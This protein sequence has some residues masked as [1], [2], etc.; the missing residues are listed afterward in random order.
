M[1]RRNFINT[2][3]SAAAGMGLG[4]CAADVM[5]NDRNKSIL[6]NGSFSVD[7]NRITYYLKEITE[8]VKIIQIADTHLWRDDERGEPY[9]QYSGRMAG[10]YNQTR[11]FRTGEPTNP[12]EA[13]QEVLKMAVEKEADLFAMTGDIFSFPSEAAIEWLKEKVKESGLKYLLSQVIMT[14]IMRVWR[15]AFIIFVK[16]G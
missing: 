10:A 4:S 12:E 6:Q 5:S 2:I 13:F 1:K 11:H 15:E 16:H 3:F 14:G 8:P 7:G 9:K